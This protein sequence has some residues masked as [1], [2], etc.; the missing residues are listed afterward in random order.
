MSEQSRRI[1]F[2]VSPSGEMAYG[3]WRMSDR[4]AL[5]F[6]LDPKNMS[7]VKIENVHGIFVHPRNEEVDGFFK[8][9]S[10]MTNLETLTIRASLLGKPWNFDWI[11]SFKNLKKLNVTGEKSLIIPFRECQRPTQFN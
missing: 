8:K 4:F 10:P 7:P 9:I 6:W 5:K 11:L 1:S 3:Q 2:L